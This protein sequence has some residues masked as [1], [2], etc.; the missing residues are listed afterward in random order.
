MST[1]RRWQSGQIEDRRKGASKSIPK[2]L[3]PE[4]EQNIIDLCC[5]NKYRDDNPYKIH[6]SLLDEGTYIASISS[7]Y[8][9]LRK[10]M[11]IKNRSKVR[12]GYHHSTPP[13]KKATGPNQVW[14]WDITYLTTEV[15]GLFYYAYV[16]IDVW[17]RS[18]VKWAIYD[19]E[20]E[21]LSRELFEKALRDNNSPDV[22]IHSDNGHPM[23][24]TT[25]LGLFFDLGICNGYSRPRVSND[26]PFI[27][28]WFKTLKYG[29]S[30]P[31]KFASMAEAR[32]WFAVFVHS[33]NTNHSHSGLHFITPNQI[34]TGQY[35]AI[36]E[37][38]NAVM[39]AAQEK[40]P[41]R[42][43]RHVKQIPE[44]HVVY[45]NPSVA[46]RIQQEKDKI[47]ARKVS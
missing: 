26:N 31:G 40:N 28:S 25:L 17:D 4:E 16:I 8:R 29:I 37:D 6:A 2:K 45:L 27:E 32:T 3:T 5:N 39:K 20:D 41:V 7:F 46:T 15:R 11:L 22:Y 18:I 12:Q 42:W 36:V 10:N 21:T 35:E 38:R 34:R 13:E 44:K 14:C 24:G 9:V 43:S 47:E 1:F 19:R 30:Y 23:K 33:Y